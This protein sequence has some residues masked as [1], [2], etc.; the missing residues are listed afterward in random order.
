[1]RRFGNPDEV[2]PAAILLLSDRLSPYTT[3]TYLVIDGGLQLHPIPLF[4]D[5]EIY[6]LNDVPFQA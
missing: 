4:T 6:K 1:M 5:E 3:G 2:G